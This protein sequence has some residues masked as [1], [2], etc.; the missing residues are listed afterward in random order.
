MVKAKGGIRALSAHNNASDRLYSQATNFVNGCA[1]AYL[2]DGP[3][4]QSS[5]V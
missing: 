2:N 3:Y 1:S 4:H 5:G